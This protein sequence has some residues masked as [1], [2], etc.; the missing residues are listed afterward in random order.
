MWLRDTSAMYNV[1]E[2]SRG[3]SLTEVFVTYWRMGEYS[4]LFVVGTSVPNTIVM[5]F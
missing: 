1:Q 3:S 2:G 5:V 4:L